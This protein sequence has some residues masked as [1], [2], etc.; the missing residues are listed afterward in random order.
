[1]MRPS[2]PRVRQSINRISQNIESANET[3]QESVYTFSQK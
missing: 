2:D 1:M 3:V